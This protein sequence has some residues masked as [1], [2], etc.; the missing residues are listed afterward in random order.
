MCMG[1]ATVENCSQMAEPEGSWPCLCA[2]HP[3]A[4]KALLLMAGAKEQNQG[5][6]RKM[7]SWSS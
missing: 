6:G 1:E 5:L 2:Q 3:R 4:D 7:L